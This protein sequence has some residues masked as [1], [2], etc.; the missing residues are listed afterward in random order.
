MGIHDMASLSSAAMFALLCLGALASPIEAPADT[1]S[2]YDIS[3]GTCGQSDLDCKYAPYAKD[4]QSGLKDGTCADQGYTEPV[5]TQTIKV[6][7][8]A[9]T[10]H[11]YD[12]SDGTCGQ[13]D[14]DCK[15]APYAK[16]F[17]SGLKDGTCAAQGYTV[18]DGT[19]TLHVPFIGDITIS[20]Y[21]KT[22]VEVVTIASAQK[23]LNSLFEPRTDTC[24][25]TGDC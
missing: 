11:L 24:S 13:S 4:F 10:C 1:C 16:D 6:D 17:Q 5:G 21:N 14:L 20:K 18:P 19:Q 15:Y 2:L 3:D 9:D 25:H 7:A 8:P 23:T 12:I 22:A